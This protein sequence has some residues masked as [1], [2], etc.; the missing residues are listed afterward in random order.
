MDFREKIEKAISKATGT[1]VK[2]EI[3]PDPSLGDYAYPCFE[4]SK[5][6]KQPPAQIANDLQKKIKLDFLKKIEVKGAYLNFFIKK[7]EVIKNTLKEISKRKKKYGLS[8]VGKKKKVIVE[9]SGPNTNK[10][11]HIGHLKNQAIGMSIIRLLEATS[12]KVIKKN[13]ISDRGI[14]ICQS[15]LAYQ[16]WGNGEKPKEK[17]DHFVGRW[18]VTFHK[19]KTEELEKEVHEMLVK[20]EKK[21]KKVRDLWKKMNDWAIDGIKETYKDFGSEF[22][23]W[24]YESKFYDKAGPIIEDGLKKKVFKKDKDGKIVAKLEKYGLPD[25]TI[26][27]ADGTSI[28]ITN[29]L[30]MTK[31]QFDKYKPNKSIWVVASEQKAYFQQL[32]KIFELLGYPWHDRCYH[33]SYGM[34]NLL[35]GKMKSREGNVVDADDLI[36]KTR[37]LAE[38]E[39][40]KRNPKLKHKELYLRS[41]KIGLAAI[42]FYLLRTDPARDVLFD[43]KSS[44]SFD[45]ETGPYLQYSLARANSILK[46][47]KAGKRFNH[48]LLKSSESYEL[49]KKFSQ[50]PEMVTQAALQLRPHLVA[51]YLLDLAQSFN[52]FYHKEKVIQEDQ[53]LQKARLKLVSAFKQ[54]MENGLKLLDIESLEEM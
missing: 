41:R 38:E 16:K 19:R 21:D 43:I 27:R 24:M 4:L 35:E 54:I 15:M 18:Y 34:V 17:S 30:A 1:E 50:Y 33:L 53:E 45:G 13:I 10:P 6:K 7:E 31:H 49:V 11:L 25:K 5:K 40:K 22:D 9:Y 20:W 14:H 8:D 29:D 37:M 51:T 36:E 2:I 3:P 44:I 46:K 52:N 39:T 12:H 47:C 48:G 26:L 28:Y 42:K 32:F 23:V